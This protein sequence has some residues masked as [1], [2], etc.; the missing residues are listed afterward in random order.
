MY[1]KCPLPFSSLLLTQSCSKDLLAAAVRGAKKDHTHP[2]VSTISGDTSDIS[3]LKVPSFTVTRSLIQTLANSVGDIYNNRCVCVCMCV[4]VCQTVNVCVLMYLH[5]WTSLKS[6]LKHTCIMCQSC[7]I[8]LL[9]RSNHDV[10]LMVDALAA[11][12]FSSKLE[13]SYRH[14][15]LKQ[16]LKVFSSACDKKTIKCSDGESVCLS[17]YIYY[18]I[19]QSTI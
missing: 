9:S 4:C 15:A 14:W 19:S 16:L 11:C 2:P 6:S 8:P 18:I 3:V 17:Q 13:L 12:L 1:L 5:V 10:A 7:D